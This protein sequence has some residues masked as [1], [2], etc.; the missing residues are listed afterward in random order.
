M[1]LFSRLSVSCVVAF[2]V[3]AGVRADDEVVG[4]I[5]KVERQDNTDIKWQFRADKKGAVWT[6]PDKG[7]PEKRGSWSGDA[8]KTVIKI[9]P[10]EGRKNAERT[11]TIVLVEK[12]PLKYQGEVEFPN[13]KKF[14][15]T[16]TLVKD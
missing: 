10:I 5:W 14:P 4:A 15:L 2:L 12:K 8:D 3:T 7:K 6:V 9:D 11:I 13:G 16:V 1:S